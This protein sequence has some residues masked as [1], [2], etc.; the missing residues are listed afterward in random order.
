MG[1]CKSNT[2][3]KRIKAN[4]STPEL[5]EHSG[6]RQRFQKEIKANYF[7]TCNISGLQEKLVTS[8]ENTSLTPNNFIETQG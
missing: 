5:D 8:F 4:V 3:S 2:N 1:A 6:I 7:F